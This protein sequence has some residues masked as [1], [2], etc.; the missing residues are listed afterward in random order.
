M[1]TIRC[2]DCG[3]E[4]T[5]CPRN[6]RYCKACRLLRDILYWEHERRTCIQCR[7]AFAPIGRSDFHCSACRP[8]IRG[9]TV[10][11]VFGHGGQQLLTGIPVCATC[12]RSPSKRAKLISALERGQRQRQERNDATT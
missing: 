8:G 1:A 6:T 5:Q 4:R 3:A 12:L 7:A 2:R 9:R 11:C 10:A